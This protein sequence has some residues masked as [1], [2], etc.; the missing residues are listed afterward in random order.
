MG[1]ERFFFFVKSHCSEN[2]ERWEMLVA[3]DWRST[4]LPLWTDG[5]APKK[6]MKR[7]RKKSANQHPS[8]EDLKISFPSEKLRWGQFSWMPRD[9]KMS[10]WYEGDLYWICLQKWHISREMPQKVSCCARIQWSWV[11]LRNKSFH[12]SCLNLP[13]QL[14][15]C[16]LVWVLLSYLSNQSLI[17]YLFKC[18]LPAHTILTTWWKAPSNGLTQ[19]SVIILKGISTRGLVFLILQKK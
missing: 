15:E 3:R 8:R 12:R 16:S 14:W 17:L 18:S 1:G 6:E 10:K 5:M 7:R 11:F 19:L 13:V 4:N 9:I 2:N